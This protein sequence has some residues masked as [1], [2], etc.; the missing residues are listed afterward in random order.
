MTKFLFLTAFVFLTVHYNQSFSQS[1]IYTINQV[2]IAPTFIGGESKLNEYVAANFITPE[3]EDTT[4]TI[5]ISFVVETDGKL[6]N[7]KIVQNLGEDFAT[8]AKKVFLKCPNF[9][10]GEL[11][12]EKVRVLMN[13][14]I[15]I[16]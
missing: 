3:V 16:R 8:A 11:N 12:G 7:I 14:P 1:T 5:K 9:L 6:T 13:Y 15:V 10:P 2:T 4:G